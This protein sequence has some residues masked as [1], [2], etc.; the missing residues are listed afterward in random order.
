MTPTLPGTLGIDFGTSNSAMAWLGPEG[1]ARLIPL[2]SEAMA[3][4]TA[5]FY[6]AED[7]STHFGRDAVRHYLEGTEGRLMR[8]LKSLL[9]SPLHLP[10]NTRLDRRL[11]LGSLA[12]GIGWGMAGLC[13][14]PAMVSMAAGQGK[15]LLFVLAMLT[16]MRLFDFLE[17][18]TQRRIKEN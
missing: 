15:A 16:G 17:R 8:S 4:P 18:Q 6:N 5:V 2:E 7:S 13:P 3:M 1:N 11:I 14:G 10:T 9:G 12:F